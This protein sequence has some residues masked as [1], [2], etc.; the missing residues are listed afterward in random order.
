MSNELRWHEK[1]MRLAKFEA[2]QKSKDPNT[3]VACL[4]VDQENSILV[5]GYNGLPRNVSDTID[6][7]SR[8]AKYDWVQHAEANA[9]SNAAR[10]GVRLRGGTA[11]VTQFPCST[12]AGQLIN[13]GI[14]RI[15]VEDGAIV[16][17]YRKNYEIATAM[18][19]EAGVEVVS[20]SPLTD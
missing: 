5:S 4:I 9:V 1:H 20:I 6:R 19:K 15:V 3:K 11:Y 8:P 17:T 7:I 12:C 14:T 10:N 2:V 16:E 18:F 13:A